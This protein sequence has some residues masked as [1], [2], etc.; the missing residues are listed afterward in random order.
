MIPLYEIDWDEKL[1][2]L[3]TR[4]INAANLKKSFNEQKR[5][6]IK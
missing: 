1:S 5:F 3:F 4:K 6:S 2:L